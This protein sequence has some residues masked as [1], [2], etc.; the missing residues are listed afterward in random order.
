MAGIFWNS[1]NNPWGDEKTHT[2]T[3][4]VWLRS[5]SYL[6]LNWNKPWGCR[7]QSGNV[8]ENPIL[9]GV[10]AADSLPPGINK[11]STGSIDLSLTVSSTASRERA[12]LHDCCGSRPRS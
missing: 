3:L 7:R 5:D 2:S 1:K 4:V 12:A 10:V 6:G 9:K 11:Q 8:G